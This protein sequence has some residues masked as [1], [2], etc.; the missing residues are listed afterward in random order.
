MEN[1]T[2][3]Q[4][5]YKKRSPEKDFPFFFISIIIYIE[6]IGLKKLFSFVIYATSS[7]F[8]SNVSIE[9]TNIVRGNYKQT[10][11]G[12]DCRKLL[13]IRYRGFD[14]VT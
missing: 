10:L 2:Y 3:F 14:P 9:L 6:F 5:N 7:I 4:Q 8:Y 12:M 11:T 13:A 1:K